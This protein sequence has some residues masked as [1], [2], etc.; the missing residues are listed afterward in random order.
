MGSGDSE[1]QQ[2]SERWW[3]GGVCAIAAGVQNQSV[4]TSCVAL[5]WLLTSLCVTLFICMVGIITILIL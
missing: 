2:R 1:L 3:W 4:V 5:G